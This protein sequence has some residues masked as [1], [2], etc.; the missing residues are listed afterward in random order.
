M[1][2]MT[3]DEMVEWN[4]W[5]DGHEFDQAPGV[6]DGQGSLA[7]CSPWGCKELDMTEQLNWTDNATQHVEPCLS[8]RCC[9]W[10]IVMSNSL[11]PHELQHARLPVLHY[12]PE[13]AQTHFHWISDAIQPSHL[14][15]SFSLPAFNLYQHH[16]LFPMSRLFAPGGQ[17]IRASASTSVLPMTVQGWF[18]LGLTGLISLLSKGLSRVFF[19]TTV[20]K[21]P[22]RAQ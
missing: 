19:S 20:W 8:H 5:L 11:R 16:G 21:L 7:C 1:P 15:S 9:F 4:H 10:V 6:G 22:V 3:E 2:H 13:F 18:S 17:T 14:L 12:L